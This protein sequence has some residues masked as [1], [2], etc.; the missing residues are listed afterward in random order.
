MRDWDNAK[1]RNL[2]SNCL[3]R[4][5]GLKLMIM[6]FRRSDDNK[7]RK[8]EVMGRLRLELAGNLII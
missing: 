7:Y 8:S 6:E 2:E 5:T 3:Q 1:A 4:K